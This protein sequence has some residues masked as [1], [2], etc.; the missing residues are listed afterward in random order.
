MNSKMKKIAFF[1]CFVLVFALNGNTFAQDD[2]PLPKSLKGNSGTTA[3][4]NGTTQERKIKFVVGGNVG[5][6]V[7]R[8]TLDLQLTPHF[9]IKPA[10]DFLC[11][12][13]G[14]TY[15]LNYRKDFSSGLKYFT[16]IFGFSGFIE[17]YI[18]DKLVLHGEYEWLSFPGNEAGRISHHGIL[19]GPGYKQ[20]VGSNFSVYGNLL[21]PVFEQSDDHAYA[22][23]YSILEIR[24]G[25]NYTF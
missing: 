23:Y 13:V 1:L 20:N 10:I 3:N 21:F 22:N 7:N 8:S 2:V 11:I 14:G 4:G 24:V 15:Y 16:H 9:G 19:I 18:W 25:F 5:F 12:G 6:G 17:G